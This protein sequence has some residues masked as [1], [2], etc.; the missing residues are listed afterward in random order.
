[1]S[2]ISENCNRAHNILDLQKSYQMFLSPQVKRNVITTNKNG[3]Y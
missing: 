1:M 2:A 3:K